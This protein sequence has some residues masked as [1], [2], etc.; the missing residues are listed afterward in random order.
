MSSTTPYSTSTDDRPSALGNN[1]HGDPSLHRVDLEEAQYTSISPEKLAT[2]VDDDTLIT[3]MTGYV[4]KHMRG[5]DPSHNPRH[6]SRVVALAH[7]LLAAERIRAPLARYDDTVVTLAALLHDIGDRKYLPKPMAA[8]IGGPTNADPSKPIDPQTM[9]RNALLDNGATPALSQRIQTIV[10]HVS[11]NTEIKNPLLTQRLIHE[12]GYPE[13]AIVQD[14]DR[15]DALGAV[16]IG[17]CF[18]Y[19]GAKGGAGGDAE[20]ELS[21]AIA[22]FVEKL[23]RLEGMMKTDSGRRMARVRTRRLKEFRRWWEDE[24]GEKG[25]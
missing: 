23:E 9:V 4:T 6:V 11:Y 24:T 1:S 22:H 10:S 8:S 21:Q 2:P 20:W 25:E 15:L 17:R 13:L 18:T 5:L 14:A 12:D 19:L 7:K 3:R 16:G